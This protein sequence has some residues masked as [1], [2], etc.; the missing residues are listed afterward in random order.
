MHLDFPFRQG[1]LELDHTVQS[2]GRQHQL[3]NLGIM[4]YIRA[5]GIKN[6]EKS[7]LT[8]GVNFFA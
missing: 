2:S 6:Q 1:I 7:A 3:S 4:Q 5:T 8:K